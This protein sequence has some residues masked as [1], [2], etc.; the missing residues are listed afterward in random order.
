LVDFGRGRRRGVIGWLRRT[1]GASRAQTGHARPAA[2]RGA[3]SREADRRIDAAR[4][5]LKAT[6]PPPEGD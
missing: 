2:P 6:I 3:S 1:L 5:R 4:R